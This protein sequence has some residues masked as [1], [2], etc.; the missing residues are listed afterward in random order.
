MSVVLTANSIGPF[1]FLVLV[2]CYNLSVEQTMP[3]GLFRKALSDTSQSLGC[4]FFLDMIWD[5]WDADTA[6]LSF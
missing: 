6:T 1:V 3:A 5:F 2:I 4:N